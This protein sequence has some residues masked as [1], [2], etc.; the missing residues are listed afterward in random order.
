M[1]FDAGSYQDQGCVIIPARRECIF[2]PLDS[3]FRR[4]DGAGDIQT[5]ANP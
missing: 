5:L 2:K 1:D 4:N 3:G